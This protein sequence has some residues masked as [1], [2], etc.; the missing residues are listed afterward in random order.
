MA[1]P[2]V[3]ISSPSDGADILAA[4]VDISGIALD[5]DGVVLVEYSINS[6]DWAEATIVGT[7]IDPAT[8]PYQWSASDL[9]I[10]VGDNTLSVRATDTGAEVTDPVV[11]ITVT[12]VADSFSGTSGVHW[13]GTSGNP[14]THWTGICWASK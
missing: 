13:R 8:E 11:T 12:R 4:T 10:D 1:G 14:T 5:A 6:G 3:T 7:P 9:P 2:A